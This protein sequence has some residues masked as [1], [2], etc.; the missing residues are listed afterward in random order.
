[1]NSELAITDTT[2]ESMPPQSVEAEQAVLGA[3]LVNGE[4]VSRV[5]DVLEPT[6]FYRKA[7]QVIFAAMLDLFD[8]SEPIDIVTVCQYLK[9]KGH[10]ENIGGR[11]Y[12]TDLAMSVATTANVEY[13]ARAVH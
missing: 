12:V 7:H 10:L 8:Q 3:L 6:Y 4:A 9:D 5:V 2:I 1:M 13:Y 11:Q